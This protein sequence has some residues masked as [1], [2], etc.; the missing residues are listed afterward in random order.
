MKPVGF[1]LAVPVD[2]A[3]GS[4][5]GMTR[6]ACLEQLCAGGVRIWAGEGTPLID[7][8]GGGCLIGVMFS[9]G[10][11][12]RLDALPCD[13]RG[14]EPVQFGRRLA[15][16]G[17]GAYIA[18]LPGRPG[19]GVDV[20]A[21]PSGLLPV[22]RFRS[23]TH[24]LVTSRPDLLAR[25]LGRPLAIAITG[26]R[27][28]LLRPE[29]RQR[30]TALAGVAELRPGYLTRIGKNPPDEVPIWQPG[31]GAGV[32]PVAGLAT[33]ARGLR[34]IAVR[35]ATA[36]ADVLGPVAVAASGGVD[37]TL[38]CAALA[39]G[40]HPFSCVTVATA[41]R[42]GDERSYV[43]LLAGQ[44]GVPCSEAFY[45]NAAF[46]PLRSASA[47]LPRP[48]RKSFLKAFDAALAAGMRNTGSRVAFDG[49]GGDNLFCFLHS[50]AP[51]LDRLR[52]EGLGRGALATLLD[53]CRVTGCDVPTMMAAV[54]RG[55]ISR[56]G[57]P[58]W[59]ADTRMLADLSEATDAI[60]PLTP[61]VQEPV[62]RRSGRLDH[63]AL[64]MRAQNHV[65]GLGDAQPRFSPLMSQPLVEY[66]LAVPTW[67]WCSGG[68][69]RAPARAAFAPAVPPELR[70]RTAKAGPDSFIRAAF[71]VHRR[72]LREMLLDGVLAAA[73]LLD[74]AAL[75]RALASDPFARG[76]LAYRVLDLAEAESWARSWSC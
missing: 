45:D 51:V 27:A 71:A 15:R 19:R 25:A 69:N 58:S 11:H 3:D 61:W 17:W 68:L 47:G 62:E 73:G 53:M 74:R 36:W 24:V 67:V 20:I 7:I 13:P 1:V 38:I 63:L 21:D 56:T 23:A 42:S 54:A 76:S 14:Q 2:A 52:G 29:L 55:L 44:L 31:D 5:A 22:Y 49:N 4:D 75:E 28:H 48:S 59:P 50:A 32:P 26:L 43:R 70:V 37:S 60:D 16:A 9:A 12:R 46:D 30:A 6:E 64:L 72:C 40:G 57:R 41:D 8:P 39:A 66:C 10:G 33:A 18:I 34:E 65:H 35:V